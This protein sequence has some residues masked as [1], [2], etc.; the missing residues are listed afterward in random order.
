MQKQQN[1]FSLNSEVLITI[2]TPTYSNYSPNELTQTATYIQTPYTGSFL[3]ESSQTT[4]NH[5]IKKQSFIISITVE[6]I[7]F[8]PGMTLTLGD[9]TYPV[10]S[11]QLKSIAGVVTNLVHCRF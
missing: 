6:Q 9:Y 5:L 2:N 10:L 1:E 3:F 4:F 7:T 8:I 11:I